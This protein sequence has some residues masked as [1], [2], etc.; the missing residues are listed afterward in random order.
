MNWV[1]GSDVRAGDILLLQWVCD[2]N[3][4]N[5]PQVSLTFCGQRIETCVGEELATAAEVLGPQIQGTRGR[6]S[7]ASFRC[8]RLLKPIAPLRADRQPARWS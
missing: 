3:A 5:R 2:R 1:T 7:R 4:M 6:T 8:R